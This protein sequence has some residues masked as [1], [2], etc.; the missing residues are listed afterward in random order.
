MS[1][2]NGKATVTRW[3]DGLPQ[4]RPNAA[5]MDIGASEI[6]VDVGPKDVENPV[7]R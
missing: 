5:G 2:S 1:K 3:H 6:W 4:M 7:R